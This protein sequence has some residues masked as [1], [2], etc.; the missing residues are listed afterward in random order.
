[1]AVA[2]LLCVMSG[3]H[4]VDAFFLKLNSRTL[5]VAS[6]HDEELLRHIKTGH[7]TKLTFKRVRNYEFHK[8]YF[9][10]IQFAFDYWEPENQVG[11]KNFNQFREDIIILAG[12]YH[13]YIRLDSTTRIKAK[14]ISFAKM[15]ED[16]FEKLYTKTIDV[17]IKH[18]CQQFTGDMLRQTIEMAEG[19]EK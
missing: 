18:I 2:L 5:V 15:S 16:E 8:K 14:S 9:A 10:L 12:Y 19:F 6:E 13:R 11:E 3:R 17:V 1:M 7:P 4:K